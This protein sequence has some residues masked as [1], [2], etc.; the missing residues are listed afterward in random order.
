MRFESFE[1]DEGG[2]QLREAGKPVRL[3]RIPMELLILLARN[4]FRLVS[5]DEI[6]ARIWGVNHYLESE[7][8]VNT[9]IRKLRKALKDDASQPRL[10]ETVS[11]KGYRFTPKTRNQGTAHI[12]QAPHPEAVRLFLQGRHVWNKKTPQ[13]YDQAIELFQHAIDQDAAFA[14]PYVG[15]AYCYVMFGIHG[16][17]PAGNVYPLARAAARSALEID[18]H[19]CEAL[20]AMADVTKGFDWN[21]KQAEE[22]YLRALQLNPEYSVAHQWYANLLSILGRHDEAI[23][24][25]VEA[26][27]CEPLS[28]GP[29]GFVGFTFYRAY[30]FDEALTECRHTLE[31]HRAA[32]IAVWFMALVLLENGSFGEAEECLRSALKIAPSSAMHLALLAIVHGRAGKKTEAAE[33]VQQLEEAAKGPRYI[34]PVDLATAYLG[35]GNRDQAVRCFKKAITERV[36]RATELQMPLFEEICEDPELA[37]FFERLRGR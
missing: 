30:K 16:L 1:I 14:Q 21:W 2:F 34:S 10:I 12:P 3:E 26:R 20:T 8:A 23:A 31:I 24:E 19:S 32:P 7:S 15:L 36:M 6:I 29:S 37:G 28:V 13:A 22:L 17:R 9:A 35:S 5:R 25:S 33:V 18:P 4:P 11:G 27:R